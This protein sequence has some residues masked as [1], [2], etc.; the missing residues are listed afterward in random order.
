MCCT[1][2]C[3]VVELC[4]EP[5]VLH[6][7]QP[8]LH[9]YCISAT[10]IN[11][12]AHQNPP[13]NTPH[14]D[15]TH[16]NTNA[17]NLMLWWNAR[18]AHSRDQAK[19]TRSTRTLCIPI[20]HRRT[21]LSATEVKILTTTTTTTSTTI[22]FNLNAVF[23]LTTII[24][25]N[26]TRFLWICLSSL[27]SRIFGIYVLNIIHHHHY[28]VPTPIRCIYTSHKTCAHHAAAHWITIYYLKWFLA[29]N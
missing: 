11:M 6:P 19:N 15:T 9:A 23:P 7:L 4:C 25:H 5:D 22:L 16:P 10:N 24:T 13:Q 12:H 26:P 28:S 21:V 20:D 27:L 3:C 2:N 1:P 17:P 8:S 29:H 14:S 18:N